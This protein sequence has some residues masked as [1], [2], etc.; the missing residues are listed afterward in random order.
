VTLLR[1]GALLVI[2]LALPILA[3]YVLRLK[4]PE[5]LVGSTLLWRGIVEDM[6]A[7]APW[8][9][10]RLS[11]LL[12]VQ[13]ITVLAL[14]IALAQPAFSRTQEFAGDVVLILDQSYSMQATDAAPTRFAAAQARAGTIASQIT[15]TNAVSVIGMGSQPTLGV[16]QSTDRGAVDAAIRRLQPGARAV[17]VP[18]ALS[19]AASLARPGQRTQAVILTDRSSGLS[20]ASLHLPFPITVFRFGSIRRD[21]GIIGFAASGGTYTH[22]LL[23]VHNFGRHN[24][25]SDLDLWGDGQLLDV[26]P[27]DVAP[28]ATIT[29]SWDHLPP[30]LTALRAH[31]TRSDDMPEDKTAWA[32]VPTPLQRKV[33]LVTRSD[34]YLETALALDPSATLQ[35]ISPSGYRA[36]G[37]AGADA[38]IFDG[39]APPPGLS[40]STLLI[41]PPAGSG[42]GITVGSQT[43]GGTLAIAPEAPRALSRYINPGDV[44]VT[45]V[46]AMKHAGWLTPVL[47]SGAVPVVLAGTQGAYR[48]VVIGFSLADT[49]WPLRISF[50]LFIHDVLHYLAPGI[51]VG[52]SSIVAGDAVPLSASAGAGNLTVTRPDGRV[53]SVAASAPAFADT[54][55]PGIYTIRPSSGGAKPVR[56][57]VNALPPDPSDTP[58]PATS[59]SGGT[60]GTTVSHVTVPV[61][62][63]WIVG[64]LALALLGTEWWVG[65]RG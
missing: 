23:K 58:A 64:L 14:A 4:R 15:A 61:D 49:D 30:A 40:A 27:L 11:L 38:V 65:M 33:L 53:D 35:V 13:L 57:A 62:V 19:L 22:A 17:N 24:A 7:N 55:L 36:V 59:R 5:R 56:F 32:V 60:S 45:R 50:P 31:L 48:E 43:P 18:A 26:R 10:L 3:L 39:V 63:S 41:D 29:F 2:A 37:S 16:A 34:Y 8:Q 42:P 1:P 44:E 46:R 6:R 9:R 28:G 12:A 52:S 20:P 54:S 25:S 21:L 51:S 47:R